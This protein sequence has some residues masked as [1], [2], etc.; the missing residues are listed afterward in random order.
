[1]FWSWGSGKYELGTGRGW[2]NTSSSAIPRG[3]SGYY[4]PWLSVPRVFS[5]E[6]E[7]KGGVTLLSI[8]FLR[9][10]SPRW[11]VVVLAVWN[12]SWNVVVREALRITIVVPTN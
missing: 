4:T 1:M 3:L 9:S 10:I 6:R 7:G 12:P 11:L 2:S 8:Y 5:V